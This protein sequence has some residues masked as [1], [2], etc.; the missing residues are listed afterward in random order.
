MDQT[1]CRLTGLK[2]VHDLPLEQANYSIGLPTVHTP[3]IRGKSLP[4][5][6]GRLEPLDVRRGIRHAC[7][8][9]PAAT[10]LLFR[11]DAAESKRLGTLEADVFVN[12][13]LQCIFLSYG[14]LILQ[15]VVSY[16]VDGLPIRAIVRTGP[17]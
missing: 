1:L 9:P 12:H 4:L 8:A 10:Q 7:N 5:L 6:I 11:Q 14:Q 15:D 3:G 17:H 2:P 13:M 16:L